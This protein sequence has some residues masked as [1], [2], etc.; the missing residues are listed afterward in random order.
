MFCEWIDPPYEK[1]KYDRPD[2]YLNGEKYDK[3]FWF[4]EKPFLDRGSQSFPL[5]QAIFLLPSKPNRPP[6]SMR[7]KRGIG[8][9]VQIVKLFEE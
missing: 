7:A 4:G 9:D 3:P 5:L 2:N 8:C 1:R 6:L